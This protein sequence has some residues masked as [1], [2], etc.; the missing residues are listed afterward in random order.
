MTSCI[1]FEIMKGL[2]TDNLSS[3]LLDGCSVSV[4]SLVFWS[5]WPGIFL[6]H[7]VASGLGSL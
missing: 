4:S 5:V 7:V 6:V 3:S 2:G 1:G